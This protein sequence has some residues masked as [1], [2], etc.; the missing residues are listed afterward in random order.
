MQADVK[1]KETEEISKLEEVQEQLELKKKERENIRRV[2]GG[3]M[4]RARHASL[5]REL[6]HGG[7]R[8]KVQDVK[9]NFEPPVQLKVNMPQYRENLTEWK[10]LAEK[11]L[12]GGVVYSVMSVLHPV[13]SATAG[14]GSEDVDFN[15]Y[16]S[17]QFKKVN[18]IKMQVD[19]YQIKVIDDTIWA[20]LNTYKV[21]IF[22]KKGNIEKTIRINQP[23]SVAQAD[24][25][26]IFIACS[27]NSG[28]YVMT[29]EGTPQLIDEGSF[30]DV[31]S[32]RLIRGTI[33]TRS[34]TRAQVSGG[35]LG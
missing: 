21:N 32:H 4:D 28:L 27:D 8:N 26:D 33:C 20:L 2:L 25:G 19:C 30:A 1:T 29:E 13:G 17:K 18:E 7:L 22:N 6:V 10:K 12:L 31:Y 24:N 16:F 11:G 3:S 14:T 35:R 9:Q 34:W 23:R 15:E 5:L